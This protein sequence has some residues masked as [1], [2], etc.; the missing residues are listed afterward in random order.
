MLI[1]WIKWWNVC[2]MKYSVR[3][4]IVGESCRV[5]LGEIGDVMGGRGDGDKKMLEGRNED[6]VDI[7]DGIRG[8]KEKVGLGRGGGD[9]MG[10]GIG[11]V[12]GMGVV[13]IGGGSWCGGSV[14]VSGG[15]GIGGR[16][17]LGWGGWVFGEMVNRGVGKV[18][19]E[20]DGGIVGVSVGGGVGGGLVGLCGGGFGG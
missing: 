11:V 17:G 12:G 14:V 1:G 13:G 3:R 10:E 6:D 8:V 4:E 9:G 7:E 5:E 16:V 20:S 18:G 15:V 19:V 2:E